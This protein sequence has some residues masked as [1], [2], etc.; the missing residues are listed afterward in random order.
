MDSK[1]FY[2]MTFT[3][4]CVCA[5]FRACI[6]L[7]KVCLSSDS[8]TNVCSYTLSMAPSRLDGSGCIKGIPPLGRSNRRSR[9]K[10]SACL[11]IMLSRLWIELCT[12]ECYFLNYL[13]TG[14]TDEMTSGKGWIVKI[15]LLL[16]IPVL[17][18]QFV[19]QAL[20]WHFTSFYHSLNLGQ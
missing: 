10:A 8:I 14:K 1:P 17:H 6:C 19:E 11:L 15:A 4:C 20:W 13:C 9:P 2:C 3:S 12:S 5:C 16:A 18:S 7:I